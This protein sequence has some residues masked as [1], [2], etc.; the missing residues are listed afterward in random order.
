MSAGPLD[1]IRVLD[2]CDPKGQYMGRL[3]A[4]HGAD[5][6]KVEP[7]DGDP[8]RRI[9]PFV[10]DV[11]GVN[12]SLF[13]WYYNADK[14]SLTIDLWQ[15]DGATLVRRIA[16]Q[17]DVVLES[18]APGTLAKLG[19]DYTTL[20]T[21]QPRLIMTSLTPFGQDGPRANWAWSDAI[22]LALGG[23]MSMCGYDDLPGTPPIR[24][25]EH[26]AFHIGSHFGA[27]GTLVALLERAGSGRGQYVDASI[28]EACAT[29][30]EA[31]MPYA[32]FERQSL[33]RQTGRHATA[34]PTE[35]WNYPAADGRA[36]NIF[37]MPRGD[38]DFLQLVE[39]AEESGFGGDLR[40]TELRDGRKR[41]LGLG[42]DSAKRM[43]RDLA[44]FIASK[45]S[46]EIYRGGQERGAAWGTLNA[47]DELLGDPHFHDRGFWVDLD[48]EDL[49]RT[50]TYPG[51]PAKLLG[52]EWALRRRAPLLGEHS[53]AIL[54]DELGLSLNQVAALAGAKIIA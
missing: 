49:G 38:A 6:I 34:R 44:A 7:L 15:P 40:D 45:P 9:G 42:Q 51:A 12:R 27:A 22:G 32:L 35:P 17:A 54:R 14:R 23:P 53:T 36:I 21:A 18:F 16:S 30:T 8:G 33:R 1:G 26:H 41:Q 47:P 20:S 3:L 43:L 48:H 28:H 29:T 37:G 50:I 25:S 10:D 31:G 24:P 52:S 11:A 39:W 4:S 46:Q 13:W 2:L 5:V 19:L